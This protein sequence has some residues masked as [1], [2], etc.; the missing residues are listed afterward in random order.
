MQWDSAVLIAVITGLVQLFKAIGV[1]AKWSPALALLCGILA[2]VFYS[3]PS[4][5]T[6]GVL[7]GCIMGLASIGFYSGPKNIA[8]TMKAYSSNRN[9]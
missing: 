5:I 4:D 7:Q 9:K 6:T 3:H 8:R 2:G 1:P